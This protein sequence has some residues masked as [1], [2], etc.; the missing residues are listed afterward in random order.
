MIPDKTVMREQY[1]Q[2]RAD[3]TANTQAKNTLADTVARY[4]TDFISK[5][6]LISGYIPIR[7]ELD[8]R[9]SMQ[10]LHA[11]GH[12]LALPKPLQDQRMI[13]THWDGST[14]SLTAGVFQIPVSTGDVCI[15]DVILLPLLAFTRSG[16]RLGYG[17]GFYDRAIAA[18]RQNGWQG[19]C[20]G[21]AYA[22]QEADFLPV[23]PFDQRLDCIV[24]ENGLWHC[25]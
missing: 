13:F 16:D 10:A 12:Q 22:L 23:D 8:I 9:P 1:R 25:R 21:T 20:I 18:L 24:T 2:R 14:Q 4:L 3:I 11:A 17:R 7:D 6:S 5:P 15:P 19:L